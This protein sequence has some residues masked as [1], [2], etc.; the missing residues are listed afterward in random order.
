M[1]ETER[2][3]L[4]P[5]NPEFVPCECRRCGAL[6]RVLCTGYGEPDNAFCVKCGSSLEH[7]SPGVA[8]WTNSSFLDARALTPNG[9]KPPATE[10]TPTLTMPRITEENILRLRVGAKITSWNRL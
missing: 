3:C 8:E 5:E 7:I 4:S 10:R 2:D 6:Y 9:V 1:T